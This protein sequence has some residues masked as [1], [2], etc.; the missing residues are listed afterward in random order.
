MNEPIY[1]RIKVT[2][3]SA[4]TELTGTLA[5]GTIKIR[6][7]AAPEKGKAN[8]ELVKFL[9]EHYH[10]PKNTISIISGKSDPLKLIKINAS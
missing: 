8:K 4:K 6:I 2:P 3:K 10:V 1:L 9:S 7:A 5:D